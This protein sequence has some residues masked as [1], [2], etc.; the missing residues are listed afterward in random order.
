MLKYLDSMKQL[1]QLLHIL[2]H[3]LSHNNIDP[4]SMAYMSGILSF[5]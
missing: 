4:R 1:I 3:A 2:S 5:Y